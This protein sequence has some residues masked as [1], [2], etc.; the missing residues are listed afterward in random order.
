[1]KNEQIIKIARQLAEAFR[2]DKGICS[3]ERYL[4]RNGVVVRQFFLHVSKGEPK[5]RFLERLNNPEKNWKFSADDTAEHGYWDD[6]MEVYEDMI[7]HTA[8]PAAPWYVVPAN[9]KWFGCG[10]VAATVIET[11][12]SLGLEYPK[13]G[14]AKLKEHVAAKAA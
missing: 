5:R 6:Y 13:V 2:V 9:N 8:S 3:F 10:V 7:R 1:V 4:S 11:L 14:R 12:A